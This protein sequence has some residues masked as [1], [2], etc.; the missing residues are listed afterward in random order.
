M[1]PKRLLRTEGSTQRSSLRLRHPPLNSAE[2]SQQALSSFSIPRSSTTD[3][4]TSFLS[5]TPTRSYSYPVAETMPLATAISSE[6][7]QD[8]RSVIAEP[9]QH[10]QRPNTTAP[11]P[12]PK[13]RR[14]QECRRRKHSH[15]LRQDGAPKTKNE[16]DEERRD[17]KP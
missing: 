1:E 12:P 6:A 15:Y 17:Q 2:L 3:Q 10:S 11:P 9:D 16:K 13:P 8:L 7:D 14:P 4:K 5:P